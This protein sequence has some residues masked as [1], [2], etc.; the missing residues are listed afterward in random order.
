MLITPGQSCNTRLWGIVTLC[1]QGKANVVRRRAA[2]T[3]SHLY[4]STLSP[5]AAPRRAA[6]AS[7]PCAAWAAR[8]VRRPLLQTAASE[9]MMRSHHPRVAPWRGVRSARRSGSLHP[10]PSLWCQRRVVS[11]IT[12]QAFFLLMTP[13]VWPLL[14]CSLHAFPP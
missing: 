7:E 8:A 4:L 5:L 11:T 1:R 13:L 14:L 6:V 2:A 9:T 3:P 12:T 10:S